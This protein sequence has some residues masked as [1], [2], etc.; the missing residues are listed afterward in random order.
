MYPSKGTVY[1][2]DWPQQDCAVRRSISLACVDPDGFFFSTAT[3]GARLA[4]RTFQT[5]IDEQ[6]G[7]AL[8][9]LW[10]EVL[11]IG[12]TVVSTKK[13]Y[14]LWLAYRVA[15]GQRFRLT[16]TRSWADVLPANGDL[17]FDCNV[18]KALVTILRILAVVFSAA[19]FLGAAGHDVHAPI[20]KSK[21]IAGLTTERFQQ[22]NISD[23]NDPL[24]V[25]IWKCRV[26]EKGRL[27]L[28]EALENDDR[29][30]VSCTTSRSGERNLLLVVEW[31]F[32]QDP[33][34]PSSVPVLL[35]NGTVTSISNMTLAD[36]RE[37]YFT[38][39]NGTDLLVGTQD[40]GQ[41]AEISI[42]EYKDH[43]ISRP[44]QV[45]GD[46][47][48]NLPRHIS[49]AI[50]FTNH[51]YAWREQVSQAYSDSPT[52]RR[53]TLEARYVWAS[54]G[55][56]ATSVLLAIIC[57]LLRQQVDI[58]PDLTSFRGLLSVAQGDVAGHG[59]NSGKV[60]STLGIVQRVDCKQL[61]LFPRPDETAA[62]IQHGERLRRL[63]LKCSDSPHRYRT[64]PHV[65]ERVSLNFC[66]AFLATDTPRCSNP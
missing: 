13:A 47:A 26:F 59:N 53:L 50:S 36:G 14:E 34:K 61:S 10:L 48:N 27:L 56:S 45:V 39:S 60:D 38:T 20:F 32:Q 5:P 1:G 55:I 22:M 43:M 2:L 16:N 65:E 23:L 58:K 3:P 9:S 18:A 42:S 29:S 37:L 46:I 25:A 8:I 33:V 40:R 35:G 52:A 51:L 6:V 30:Q 4:M 12:V 7:Y 11:V 28:Y 62:N 54:V 24:V 63:Q 57:T 17:P 21:R 19:S 64:V 44:D 41:W 49:L 31:N 66:D 15:G